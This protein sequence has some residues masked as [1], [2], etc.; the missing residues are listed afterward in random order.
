MSRAWPHTSTCRRSTAETQWP[1]SFIAARYIGA[2]IIII[3]VAAVYIIALQRRRRH[4]R[5]SIAV[6]GSN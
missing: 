5:Y 6:L 1:T 2:H 3:I 4:F